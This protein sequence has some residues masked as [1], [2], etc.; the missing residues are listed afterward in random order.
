MVKIDRIS[1]NKTGMCKFFSDNENRI[2]ELMWEKP[3]M[4]SSDMQTKLPDMSLSCIG[5]TLD[6]LVKSGFAERKAVEKD[7]K[8]RYV[9]NPTGTRDEVG[10]R[11]SEKVIGSLVETFG[12]AVVANLGKYIGDAKKA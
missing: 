11:I 12:E 10:E 5:G 1:L 8:V 9:Y 2:M 3:D 6:R 4:T 7:G